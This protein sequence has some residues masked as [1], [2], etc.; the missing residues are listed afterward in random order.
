M[1][2][3]VVDLH[4]GRFADLHVGQSEKLVWDWNVSVAP[5]QRPVKNPKVSLI[6]LS[7]EI[8]QFLRQIKL[9]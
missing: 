9:P 7:G 4:V 2:V 8:F 1:L 5:K 3:G 6:I